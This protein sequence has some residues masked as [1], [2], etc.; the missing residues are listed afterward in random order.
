MEGTRQRTFY[1]VS[2]GGTRQMLF[3]NPK[4]ILCRLLVIGHSTKFIFKLKK[5]LPCARS[6]ALGK[7]YVRRQISASSSLHCFFTPRRLRSITGHPPATGAPPPAPAPSGYRR[8]SAMGAPLPNRP[9]R[10]LQPSSRPRVWPQPSL[11]SLW[12]N[13]PNY[14]SLSAQVAP[15]KAATH[16]NRNNPSVPRI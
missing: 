4:V 6:Q 9:R 2:D 12:Q 11:S 10:R 7:V 13:R 5:S 15:L 1:R 8:C 14:S 3:K 16:L